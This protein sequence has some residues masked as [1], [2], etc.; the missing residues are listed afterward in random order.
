MQRMAGMDAAF[1]YIET[2]TM[3]MH[4]VGVLVLDPT[5]G[6][7]GFGIDEVTRV[8]A[9]RIHLIPPL[10]RRVLPSPAGIDHPLWIEDPAFDLADHIRQAAI[11]GP[12]SWARLEQFVGDVA[13][14]PLD[15]TRPLWEMWVV[16]ALED[17]TVALVTK[18]HHSLMDGGAAAN[19][20]A[21][22]FDLSA[23]AGPVE[24]AAEPWVPDVVP[25]THRQVASSVSSLVARQRDVPKAVARTFLGLAGTSRT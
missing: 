10:R 11:E 12:V 14:K 23:D 9:D 24:P 18:L 5:G 1:L 20:M 25:S 13:G 7:G 8:M 4:V 16:D 3:H 15:R 6:P 2:R 21:S 17:G 19:L 22:I